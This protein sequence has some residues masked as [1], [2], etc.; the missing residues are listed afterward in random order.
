MNI[1]RTQL[2]SWAILGCLFVWGSNFLVGQEYKSGA[3]I[4]V[5]KSGDV[6]LRSKA[7]ER[8]PMV[9]VGIQYHP[10]IQLSGNDGGLWGY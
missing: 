5:S 2:V 7:G 6:V 1:L 10:V 4:L 8:A 3:L 9:K